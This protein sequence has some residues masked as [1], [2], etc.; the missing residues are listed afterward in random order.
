MNLSI[1]QNQTH[2]HKRQTS[3]YPLERI[4]Q[5]VDWESGPSKYKPV[6][7]EEI[8]KVLL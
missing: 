2:R 3:G 5:G 7:R 8:N 1:N 4:G 6:Y